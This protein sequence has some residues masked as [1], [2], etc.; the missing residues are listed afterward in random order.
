VELGDESQ[1]FWRVIWGEI[2]Q[3]VCQT[4]TTIRQPYIELFARPAFYAGERQSLV[5]RMVAGTLYNITTYIFLFYF[6]K[7]YKYFNTLCA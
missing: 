1:E 3:E 2:L 6:I 4:W 7:K 5:C